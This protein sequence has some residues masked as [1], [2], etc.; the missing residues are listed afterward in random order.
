MVATLASRAPSTDA[1]TLPFYMIER[2]ADG[3]GCM[4][5]AP[6]GGNSPQ[7]PLSQRERVKVRAFSEVE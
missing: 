5:S 2:K 1:A 3:P 6:S 7:Y 4:T